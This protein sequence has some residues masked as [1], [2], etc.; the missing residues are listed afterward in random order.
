MSSS[1]LLSLYD[2]ILVSLFENWIVD[3]DLCFV[4][5][6][7]CNHSSRPGFLGSLSRVK[8]VHSD[9]CKENHNGRFDWVALRQMELRKL[10]LKEGNV[11]CLSSSLKSILMKTKRLNHVELP[12]GCLFASIVKDYG[13]DVLSC[14]LNK[15]TSNEDLVQLISAFPNLTSLDV[16]ECELLSEDSCI[17]IGSYCPNLITLKTPKDLNI[18]FVLESC[19]ALR[20]ITGQYEP[21]YHFHSSLTDIDLTFEDDIDDAVLAVAEACPS[22][23]AF[24]TECDDLIDSS[25][26]KLVEKCHCLFV[27][28][29][30]CN[31]LTD[32]TALAIAS[33]CKNLQC[34]CLPSESL[35]DV[36]VIAVVQ[37]NKNLKEIDIRASLITDQSL[38]AIS[39]NC[40]LLTILNLGQCSDITKIGLFKVVNSCKLLY[41]ITIDENFAAMTLLIKFAVN[42]ESLYFDSPI[43]SV[44][45]M[46]DN[47][48]HLSQFSVWGL[49]GSFEELFGMNPA[50][51]TLYMHEI[52][53]EDDVLFAMVELC[54]QLQVIMLK[55]CKNVTR[56]VLPHF[57]KLRF[58]SKVQLTAL[59]NITE[60]DVTALVQDKPALKD[61]C[62][63][64]CPD[65]KDNVIAPVAT[66]C[67]SLRTMWLDGAEKITSSAVIAILR[68][69]AR[70][71]NLNLEKCTNVDESLLFALQKDG[72]E[73][74]HLNVK[75]CNISAAS[76]CGFTAGYGHNI[77]NLFF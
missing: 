48:R 50:L 27:L 1:C 34:L 56:A 37:Q 12:K 43:E 72:R 29:L 69:S 31:G 35:T 63:R 21:N 71:D 41:M 40:K 11:V 54:P 36:G 16:S 7:V 76:H 8:I 58:L 55:N 57:G 46:L 39:D 42:V 67:S 64:S 44:C 19:K 66:Y 15:S 10:R 38:T 3:V 13:I 45:M 14:K 9:F 73:M 30:F 53:I 52:N 22:L 6:A 18:A 59:L 47:N 17:A 65:I 33:N 28:K 77:S 74:I 60:N 61:L 24:V 62:F 25:V 75:G 5:T 2:A 26:V 20:T 68:S 4:D 23:A 51:R 49:N 70:L 32:L